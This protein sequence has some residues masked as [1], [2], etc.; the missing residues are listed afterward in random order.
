[1][2]IKLID[3]S[4]SVKI[5]IIVEVKKREMPF[6]SI[7][8]EVLKI[9]GYNVRLIPFRSMC[10]WKL[11]F[12]KPDI[13]LINGLRTIDPYFI[14]QIYIPKKLF[15]S[16][17]ACYYSEQVGYYDKS[18]AEDYKNKVILDNVDYH[19]SWGPRF[20]KDL[21]TMGVPENKLWYIGSLQYDIDKYLKKTSESIKHGLSIKYNIPFDR[22]WI[23]YA[24]NIVEQYQ[25]KDL[26]ELRRQ[27]T[28]EMVEKVSETNKNSVI[29]FRHHPDS[30]LAEIEV[31]RKRF[32]DRDNIYVISEGHIFD[33]TCGISALIMWNSTS[34]LQVMFM[35][36]P[37]FGFMTSDGKNLENYWYKDI[38]PTFEDASSLAQAVHEVLNGDFK[39]NKQ[40]EINKEKYISDWYFKKDGFSFE[41]MC[42]LMGIISQENF[43]PLKGDIHY[44]VFKCSEI[45]YYE[46]RS[47]IGDIIKGRSI[48]RNVTSVDIKDELKKYDLSNFADMNFTVRQNESGNYLE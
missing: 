18:I 8:N 38:F 46:I 2:T 32:A 24:D 48:E 34:S 19:I 4:N 27:D 22:E 45:L 1:M 47:W 21:M 7:L 6:M 23:M 12:F 39:E 20:S 31:A 25:P 5:A 28:F 26:Y 37:V 9:K 16:K 42:Y 43:Q 36:K 11:L 3:M 17:I 44:N 40:V 14:K 29:I 35:G 33:W 10:T 30:T 41:R 15:K 13:I